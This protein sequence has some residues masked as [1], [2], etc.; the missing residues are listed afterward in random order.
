MIDFV[1]CF[2]SYGPGFKLGPL[3]FTIQKGKICGIL[4]VNGSGKTTVLKS[5]LDEVKVSQGEIRKSFSQKELAYVAQES[6]LEFPFPLTINEF[7]KLGSL[8]SEEPW[9]DDLLSYYLKLVQLDINGNQSYQSL[10]GGQKQRINLARTLA[11]NP[12]VLLLDESTT[13]LDLKSSIG[14]MDTIQKLQ[15]SE[16][17]TILIT[18]HHHELLIAY[19]DELLVIQD[20]RVFHQKTDAEIKNKARKKLLKELYGFEARIAGS[21]S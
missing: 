3:D 12:Q 10:S 8:C 1:D 13:G 9:S 11:Q 16:D 6:S 15:N 21:S 17:L 5:I 7:V 19:C 2:L 20:S 14:F 18:S 4:G